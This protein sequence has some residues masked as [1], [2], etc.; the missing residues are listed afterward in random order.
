MG[1]RFWIDRGGTF[2]DL[3][4]CDRNGALH[5]RKLLSRSVGNWLDPAVA[6]I[7]TYWASRQMHHCW[8]VRLI[9][10]ISKLL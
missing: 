6:A 8:Q 2:T 5:V 4:G 3:I 9:V 7:K 10:F 1:W